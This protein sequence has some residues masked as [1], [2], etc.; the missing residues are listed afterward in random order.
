MGCGV[1]SQFIKDNNIV[2]QDNVL[3]DVSINYVGAGVG[4]K[5]VLL[6]EGQH[7]IQHQ[8][9]Y[10]HLSV[11]VYGKVTVTTDDRTVELEGPTSMVIEAGVNHYVI[12][13]TDALWMCVHNTENLSLGNLV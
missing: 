6:K 12:A 1:V 11:L 7:V 8:H 10:A 3:E 4:V 9:K 2:M 13:H 5:Q